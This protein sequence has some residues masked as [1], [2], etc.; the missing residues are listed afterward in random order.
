MQRAA[1]KCTKNYN[2]RVQ[3]LLCSS[4]LLFIDGPVAVAFVVFLNSLIS[5][6]ISDVL[7]S[8]LTFSS[9]E[10]CKL[11][12]TEAEL[13]ITTNYNG[14]HWRAVHGAMLK[15]RMRGE[16]RLYV[17]YIYEIIHICT[18]VIDESEE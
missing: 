1:K 13:I 3:P 10:A 8:F 6:D 5:E 16:K 14:V 9:L 2:A 17:K 4:N 12:G 18:A 11:L 7:L 15:I